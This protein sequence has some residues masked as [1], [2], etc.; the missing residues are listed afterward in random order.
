MSWAKNN[1]PGT[2]LIVAC[3]NGLTAV[4]L[5]LVRLGSDPNFDTAHFDV[6]AQAWS[7][8]IVGRSGAYHAARIVHRSQASRGR[9]ALRQ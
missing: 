6:R 2:A 9:W 3:L 8:L 4:A 5:E 1:T 7:P